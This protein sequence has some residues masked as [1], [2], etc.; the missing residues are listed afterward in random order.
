MGGGGL[1]EET[2][3]VGCNRPLSGRVAE[4]EG[5]M[6]GLMRIDGVVKG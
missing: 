4:F 1:V 3:I 5:L 2:A 6:K